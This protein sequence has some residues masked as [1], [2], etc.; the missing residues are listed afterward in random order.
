M[1]GLLALTMVEQA[2]ARSSA[3]GVW[4][5][6]LLPNTHVVSP[7]DMQMHE[8]LLNQMGAQGWELVLAPGGGDYYYF[9]RPK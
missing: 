3:F 2:S 5:Y 8:Q 7:D 1:I 6:K 4:E 9:K